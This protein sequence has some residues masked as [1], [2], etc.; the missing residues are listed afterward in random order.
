MELENIIPKVNSDEGT[1]NKTITF[2]ITINKRI[3]ITVFMIFLILFF[4]I[5]WVLNNNW[6]INF[7]VNKNGCI[8]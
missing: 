2:P 8:G 5:I 7:K 4:G 6:E 3:V 1:N